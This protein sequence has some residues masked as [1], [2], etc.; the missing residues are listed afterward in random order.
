MVG[1]AFIGSVFFL[2]VLLAALTS[3]ISLMETVV[4]TIQD[5]W[6]LGRT[7][8]CLVVL[9]ISLALGTLSCLGYSVWSD[10][11]FFGKFQVLDFFD[12]LTNSLMMPII[13]ISTCIFVAYILGTKSIE[14]E[15]EKTGSD[16]VV[17]DG[18]QTATA[19]EADSEERTVPTETEAALPIGTVK[20]TGVFKLKKLYRVMIRYIAPV[21]LLVILI[22]SILEGLGIVTF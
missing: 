6:K 16:E 5:K 2:M 20:A 14:E 22:F 11:A 19:I 12:F 8:S 7:P 21:C 9:G 15:V 17:A 10:F 13:A 1:G 18:E 3:S 4:A